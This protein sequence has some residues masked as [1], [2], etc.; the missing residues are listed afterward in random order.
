VAHAR[1]QLQAFVNT[2]MNFPV[3]IKCEIREWLLKKDSAPWSLLRASLSSCWVLPSA[4]HF[5]Y[6]CNTLLS[7][8]MSLL[9][10]FPV[11]SLIVA[12]SLFHLF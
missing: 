5:P 11:T 9:E 1:D 10:A 7:V 8:T 6:Y 12:L 4:H 2:V 3:S